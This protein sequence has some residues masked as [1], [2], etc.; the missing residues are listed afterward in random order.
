M[1]CQVIRGLP[2]QV[3]F[4]EPEHHSLSDDEETQ[5]PLSI[6]KDST[7]GLFVELRDDLGKDKII[8]EICPSCPTMNGLVRVLVLVLAVR[9]GDTFPSLR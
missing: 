7:V 8:D 3:N 1:R 6:F 9:T 2:P 5:I 4:L